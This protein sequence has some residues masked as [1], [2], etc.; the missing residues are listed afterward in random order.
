MLLLFWH[1]IFLNHATPASQAPITQSPLGGRL[2]HLQE[3]TECENLEDTG[4]A[5]FLE[6]LTDILPT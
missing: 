1:P 4:R 5:H 2:I 6:E 3:I